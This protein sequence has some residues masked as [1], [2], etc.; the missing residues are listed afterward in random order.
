MRQVTAAEFSHERLGD[1]FEQSLSHYD[2]RRRVEV[3][4][5]DFLTD[6]LVWGKD[7]LEV[8]CGL[9]FFSA[10]LKERGARVLATDLGEQLLEKVRL[11]V[12]C[13]CAWADALS[14]EE[15]FGAERFDLVVSSE[16][17]EHTPAPLR[18]LQ[19]MARVLKPGG[20]LA[21]STPNL[22]WSPLVKLATW[23][24]LRPFDGFENFSTW[25]GMRR[26]LRAE[27]VDIVREFG[28]HLIP[29]QLK[30][31]RLSCWFDRHCQWARGLMINI[32]I[33]GRKGA[34]HANAPQA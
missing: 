3:L 8:G 19:Q 27:G 23:L 5:D 2:T 18:A 34:M 13:E 28:L 32:C 29:F 26:T 1:R 15:Q 10:R 4:I 9:G 14:L 12:G 16:C 33:L 6:E 31:D 24:T 25:R 22:V 20:Y 30:L 21:V 11:R 7:A 17:I